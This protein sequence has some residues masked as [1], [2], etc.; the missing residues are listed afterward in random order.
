VRRFLI[1]LIALAALSAAAASSNLVIS[2]AESPGAGAD[3]STEAQ[4]QALLAADGAAQ[5]EV[6][7]WINNN[8]GFAAS[9][10]GIS[11]AELNRRIL[12]R[13]EPVRKAYLDFLEQHPD[14][15]KARVVYGS[16]LLDLHDE[17]GAQA[18]WEQALSLETNNPAIYV[19][20]ANLYAEHGPRE[21]AFSFFET[22]IRLNPHQPMYYHSFADV[23]YLFHEDAR[24]FYHLDE[25]EVVEKAFQLY[26]QALRLDP[27]NFPYATDAASTFYALRPVPFSAA[28]QAWTNALNLAHNEVERQGI[29]LH[30][31]RL[32]LAAGH[33][34]AARQCL[35]VVIDARY[36]GLKSV[37][38]SNVMR[39]ESDARRTNGLAPP[40]R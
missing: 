35:E 29:Y 34:D 10:G 24:Q 23:V 14:H 12:A 9:G 16:L 4:Y 8:A 26:S 13:F 30:F 1:F 33:F 20:L 36:A 27:T 2:A 6:E 38:S 25:K 22:A 15:V 11:D 37:M 18:Q 5:A 31:A 21:K 19:D 3:P 32:N 7:E 40:S 28:L 17:A 39:W